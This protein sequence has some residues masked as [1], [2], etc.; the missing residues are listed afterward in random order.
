[1]ELLPPCRVCLITPGHLATNPR[2]VKEADALSEAGYDVTVIAADF[3]GWAR[4][5]DVEFA[6]R[7]WRWACKV[8]CGPRAPKLRYLKQTFRRRAARAFVKIAGYPPRLVE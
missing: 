3:L 4:T 5:A 6:N 2:I 1:M 8:P 7:P